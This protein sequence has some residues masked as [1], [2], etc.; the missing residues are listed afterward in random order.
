M[1]S[2]AEIEG[3]IAKLEDRI[4]WLEMA[5]RFRPDEEAEWRRAWHELNSLKKQLKEA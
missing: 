4:W 1:M 5:D 3:R 2:K